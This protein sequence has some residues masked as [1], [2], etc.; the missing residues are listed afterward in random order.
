MKF[1]IVLV[2]FFLK[3]CFLNA[4]LG[5][6][7]LPHY[8]LIDIEIESNIVS[9][10]PQYGISMTDGGDNPKNLN[11]YILPK[12]KYKKI[13]LNHENRKLSLNFSTKKTYLVLVALNE[14]ENNMINSLSYSISD[15]KKFSH[16]IKNNSNSVVEYR[17]LGSQATKRN[18][19]SQFKKALN[20]ASKDDTIIFYWSGL[21]IGKSSKKYMIP[22]EYSG[23][24]FKK[25]KVI[26]TEEL[27]K[28][29]KDSKKS[30]ILLFDGC[31]L[32]LSSK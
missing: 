29:A 24:K 17:L 7:A 10:S 21:G 23:Y 5:Q 30:V 16:K 9:I 4:Y 1:K 22:Y 26:G 14:Y 28:L 13:V 18:I 25:Y 3:G 19:I 32:D 11:S 31:F 15:A 12:I 20:S 2:M 8:S 27:E 6:V